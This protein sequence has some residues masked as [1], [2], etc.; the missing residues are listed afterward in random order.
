[1]AVYF[2]ATGGRHQE[3]ATPKFYTLSIH[4]DYFVNILID[5]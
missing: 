1:M 5:P 4:A 2:T 3:K